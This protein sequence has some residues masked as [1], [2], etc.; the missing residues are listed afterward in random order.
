MTVEGSMFIFI[1][2]C[3]FVTVDSYKI[4]VFSPIISRSH[5]ISNGR[6]AD[7]LAMAGHDVG[8]LEAAFNE[9]SVLREHQEIL[10]YSRAYIKLC[11][12]L[13]SRKEVM[14]YLRGEK[15]DAYFGEHINLCG[16]GM[17]YVLGIKSH[18]LVSSCPIS[19]YMAWILGM[20]QPSSYIPSL[21]GMDITHRPTYFERI[22]NVWA[23]AVFIY[24]THKT[25]RETTE[26]FRRRYGANFPNLEDIAADS[27]LVFVSTDEFVDMPRPTLPNL[28]HIGGLGQDDSSGNGGLDKTFSEQMEKGSKGVV[29]FSLGTVVNTS[30]LPAFA[31][32]A[33]MEAARQ[34]PDYHFILAVDH[35]DQVSNTTWKDK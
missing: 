19:D 7:E 23:T 35:Y 16:N 30:S 4:L 10:K 13:L 31:M 6:I 20:T 8:F 5:M 15:F 32:R 33:V 1:L 2:L 26:V 3:F 27:D 17:A 29:Y 9:I 12:D 11:D 14:E 34:T 18:F 21:I 24:Y 22:Q 25:A 28:V